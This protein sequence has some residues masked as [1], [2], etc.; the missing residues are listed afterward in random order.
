M[1][2][3][4]EQ[5]KSKFNRD[6][7]IQDDILESNDPCQNSFEMM[8]LYRSLY[9][10]KRKFEIYKDQIM[11]IYS[12]YKI[13]EIDIKDNINHYI[14]NIDSFDAI[15]L[16]IFENINLLI[17]QIY[18][19][20]DLYIA[21]LYLN[22]KRKYKMINIFKTLKN[23]LL[24]NNNFEKYNQI[25]YD[26]KIKP[27]I[28]E[29]D[30]NEEEEKIE[31]KN[32]VN[33]EEEE[34]E[35]FKP[36]NQYNKYG[37]MIKHFSQILNENI[38][39]KHLE[40]FLNNENEINNKIENEN[41]NISNNH[42]S[43]N[44]N[45]IYIEAFPFI[46]G[47][48][49][50]KSTIYGI[51]ETN[52]DLTHELNILFDNEIL[53]KINLYEK[54]E[55]ERKYREKLNSSYGKEFVKYL[56]EKE[57]IKENIRV[58]EKILIEKKGNNQ[59]L[60]LIQDMLEKLLAQKIWVEQKIDL[61]KEEDNFQNE[62][63]Y[64]NKI[65]ETKNNDFM[66]STTSKYSNFIPI[67]N[68]S[69][70][71]IQLN[72]DMRLSLRQFSP[73]NKTNHNFS[74][75]L[76]KNETKEEKYI[77]S[78]KEIFYFYS[79]QHNNAGSSPLFSSI[80]EKKYNIDLSEF[81]KFCNEFSIAITKQKLTEIFKRN[82]SN[83]YIMNF[84]EFIKTIEELSEVLHQNKKKMLLKKISECQEKINLMEIK[85]NNR[86]L[87]EKNNNLFIEKNTGNKIKRN[88][89]KNQ[90]VYLSKRKKVDEEISKLK[91]QY[92]KLNKF[93]NNQIKD[94]FYELLGLNQK[95][96]YKKK[97]KGFLIPFQIHDK[98]SRIPINSID[99]KINNNSEIKRLL[100]FQKEEKEKFKLSKKIINDDLMYQ[101]KLKLFQENNKKLE[102]HAID[103]QKENKYSNI[104]KK[105]I[106]E[107]QLKEE[108]K[109]N[110]ISWNSLNMKYN[111]RNE[112]QKNLINLNFSIDVDGKKNKQ[113]KKNYSAVELNSNDKS[114][115]LPIIN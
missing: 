74:I 32:I 115:K 56:N 100:Q 89:E 27:Y 45:T 72:Q 5:N 66:K 80:Q 40:D 8:A 92:D 53:E 85:E 88:L 11:E 13:N 15:G 75:K 104:M 78:L 90:F 95:Y 21:N 28:I 10:I 110:K 16:E 2:N 70:S 44:N 17:I 67:L 59:N 50:Q 93:T 29:K 18:N 3:Q 84:N 96:I 105:R 63:I 82:S 81:L 107:T 76:I 65:L 61:L 87:E 77:S 42:N 106:V 103:R 43:K 4:N 37:K 60:K 31:E 25:F 24:K 73:I 46:L 64:Q 68:K 36:I 62:Q 113:I 1:S 71:T 79:N 112:K 109:K 69:N 108:E 111:L 114:Y 91:Y 98:T 19:P 9:I 30:N 39:N 52:N 97:M 12:K 49:L 7:I 6:I 101:N 51:I 102:L 14:I 58:Y 57:R 94:T 22:D 34:E 86:I 48:F 23:Y 54:L 99:Y 38:S 47:D 41:L 20:K 83:F 26:K 55:K 35:I 33:K